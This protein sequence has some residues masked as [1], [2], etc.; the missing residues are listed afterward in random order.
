MQT[1]E[2]LQEHEL[3][4]LL[5]YWRHQRGKSQLDLSLD[6][7][8]SQR[9]LSFVE[10]GRSVPSRDLLVD[11]FR[12]AGHSAARAECPAARFG[13]RSNLQRS[14]TQK[15]S[16]IG[17]VSLW[18]EPICERTELKGRYRCA[19]RQSHTTL[20]RLIEENGDLEHEAK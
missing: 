5:R 6:T 1:H 11:R 8:I 18:S 20:V 4:N 16:L 13:L 15:E 7:G 12:E 2:H 3:G 19:R 9:H 17:F 10:S 14:W